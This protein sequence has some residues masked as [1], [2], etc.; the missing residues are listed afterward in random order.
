LNSTIFEN[1]QKEKEKE[2]EKGNDERREMAV[3]KIT[4]NETWMIQ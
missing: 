4:G 3:R 1:L 2:K